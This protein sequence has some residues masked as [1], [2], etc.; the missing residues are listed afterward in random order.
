MSEYK[1][2][3]KDHATMLVVYEDRIIAAIEFNT[4]LYIT[5]GD[6]AGHK[7]RLAN[8]IEGREDE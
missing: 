3:E 4:E 5:H 1:V 2:I 8:L 6:L 7:Y